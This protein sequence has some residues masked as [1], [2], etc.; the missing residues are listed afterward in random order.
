M[1]SCGDVSLLLHPCVDISSFIRFEVFWEC[2]CGRRILVWG[3]K[4]GQRW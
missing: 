1:F 2:L 3:H 4:L